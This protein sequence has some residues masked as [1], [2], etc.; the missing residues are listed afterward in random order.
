MGVLTY[1]LLPRLL[2]LIFGWI[3]FRINLRRLR[4]DSAR[5]RQL[6]QRM[7]NPILEVQPLARETNSAPTAMPDGSPAGDK[8]RPSSAPTA[9]GAK[10]LLLPDELWEQL[11]L[12]QLELQLTPHEGAGPYHTLRI[13]ALGQSE[14]E[15]F[16]SIA[17]TLH[18]NAATGIVMLQ[19]AW[20]PPLRE[21]VALLRR[22]RHELPRHY[23]LS[24]VLI[25]KPSPDTLLTRTRPQ[26]LTLWRKTLQSLADPYLSLYPLV[27]P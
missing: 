4:F 13:G 7:L 22:I 12:T 9:N 20:Q 6:Q 8:I 15:L 18:E 25:G 23:P 26:D 16:V 21:M 19:E 27:E 14:E 17:R 1:G 10:L 2:L 3:R 11:D 24:V 5:F